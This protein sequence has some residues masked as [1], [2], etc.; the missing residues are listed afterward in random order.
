MRKKCFKFKVAS[1][2]IVVFHFEYLSAV[3][4]QSAHGIRQGC[5]LGLDVSVS[6]RRPRDIPTSRLGL[7]SRKIVDVSV[8]SRSRPFMSRAQDHFLPNCA[9]HINKTSQFV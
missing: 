6:R 3:F 1:V 9:G 8:S 5:G 7:V 2:H 4:I